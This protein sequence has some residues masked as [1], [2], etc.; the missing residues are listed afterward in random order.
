MA[1]DLLWEKE[2]SIN[3]SDF[4]VISQTYAIFYLFFQGNSVP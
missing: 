1:R 4:V 2:R 3:L